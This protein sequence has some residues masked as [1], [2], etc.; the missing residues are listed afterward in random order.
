[1]A[2][3]LLSGLVLAAAVAAAAAWVLADAREREGRGRPVVATVANLTVERPEAWAAL[4]LVVVVLGLP[5]YL[6][7]RRAS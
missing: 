5:L 4:C 6:T 1:M 7:A 3:A 2:P